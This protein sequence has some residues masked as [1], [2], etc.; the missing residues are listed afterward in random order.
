MGSSMN[1][2][3]DRV[4]DLCPWP[5]W[6]TLSRDKTFVDAARCKKDA[7]KAR[8]SISTGTRTWPS[9]SIRGEKVTPGARSNF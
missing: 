5:V 6:Q 4:R 8:I 3:K 9:S 7:A 2:L 1:T